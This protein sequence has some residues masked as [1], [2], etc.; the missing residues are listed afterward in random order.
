MSGGVLD[1]TYAHDRLQKPEVRFRYRIRARIVVEAV[2]RYQ[3]RAE[4]VRDLDLGSAEGRAQQ[5]LHSMLPN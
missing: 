2:R 4:Q 3:G 5:E 1:A